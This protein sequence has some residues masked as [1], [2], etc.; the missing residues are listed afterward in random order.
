MSK[1]DRSSAFEKRGICMVIQ[2]LGLFLFSVFCYGDHFV[3]FWIECNLPHPSLDVAVVLHA[4]LFD[5]ISISYY[6]EYWILFFFNDGIYI[7]A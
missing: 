7:A 6:D 3:D 1:M 4:H 2:Q 5:S